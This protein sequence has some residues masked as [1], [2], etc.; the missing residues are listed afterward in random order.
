MDRRDRRET[1]LSSLP[2]VGEDEILEDD[3]EGEGQYGGTRTTRMASLE[4]DLRSDGG[5]DDDGSG[6]G[7]GRTSPANTLEKAGP[8]AFKGW[9]GGARKTRSGEADGDMDTPRQRRGSSNF[10]ARVSR[11]VTLVTGYSALPALGS[12]FV[13]P[14]HPMARAKTCV[15]RC[16]YVCCCKPWCRYRLCCWSENKYEEEEK[17]RS[18]EEEK[19]RRAWLLPWKQRESV[20]MRLLYV[21]QTVPDEELREIWCGVQVVCCVFL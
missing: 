9:A 18:K 6:G 11:A 13:P 7:G 19:K 17:R 5:G 3:D 10:E 12:T 15:G 16:C 1:T 20:C 2:A 4:I 21:V 14:P 8:W